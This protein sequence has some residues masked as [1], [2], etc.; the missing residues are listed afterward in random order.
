M[1][2]NGVRLAARA[3]NR[4]ELAL[5]AARRASAGGRATSGGARRPC[6]CRASLRP[7]VT[8]AVCVSFVYRLS[9]PKTDWPAGCLT[10]GPAASRWAEVMDE[11]GQDAASSFPEPLVSVPAHRGAAS[12]QH[13]HTHTHLFIS[14]RRSSVAATRSPEREVVA[15]RGSHQQGGT[16]AR[17]TD[18]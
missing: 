8:D 13:T 11:A 3:E 15:K 7:I 1:R 16:K 17:V 14:L 10:G 5:I 4:T 9:L 6:L 2:T 12:P 18:S